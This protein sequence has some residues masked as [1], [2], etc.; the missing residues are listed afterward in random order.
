MRKNVPYHTGKVAIGSRYE[1]V[2]HHTMSL[3]EIR[4]QDALIKPP[5][6][7]IQLPYDRVIY[8]LGIVALVVIY[9]TR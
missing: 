5:V 1:P 3:D 7:P 9:L 4:I 2:K 6:K 8:V